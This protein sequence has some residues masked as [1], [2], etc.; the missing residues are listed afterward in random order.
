MLR[1]HASL[2]HRCFGGRCYCRAPSRPV[3]AAKSK[4]FKRSFVSAACG[5]LSAADVSIRRCAQDVIEE[6]AKAMISANGWNVPVDLKR[7]EVKGVLPNSLTKS[8]GWLDLWPDKLKLPTTTE[9]VTLSV[10][11][12][13][14]W[15]PEVGWSNMFKHALVTADNGDCW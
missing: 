14:Y 13:V 4:P 2:H 15:C 6:A 10:T 1:S 11:K 9:E 7:G 3:R 8:A 5:N 12:S